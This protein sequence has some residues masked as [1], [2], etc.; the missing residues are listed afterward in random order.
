MKKL[1]AHTISAHIRC[2]PD[3]RTDR[4]PFGEGML[5]CTHVAGDFAVDSRGLGR[6]IRLLPKSNCP[7]EISGPTP[8]RSRASIKSSTERPRW[9]EVRFQWRASARSCL[10]R[11]AS[12][13]P[14]P[15][16]RTDDAR[17][18]PLPLA[19]P[20]GRSG[21]AAFRVRARPVIGRWE[22][23]VPVQPLA[24]GLEHQSVRPLGLDCPG[25]QRLQYR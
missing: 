16:E 21:T 20:L 2:Q 19:E 13:L 23:A 10:S 17:R 3:H 12:M 25:W 6:E 15:E 24:H 22:R 14:A 18:R 8:S 4:C 11:F 9:W 7:P 5:V 1:C